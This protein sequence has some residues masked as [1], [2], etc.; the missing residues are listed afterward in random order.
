MPTWMRLVGRD[1]I[2][3]NMGWP[4][5]WGRS[6]DDY[7]VFTHLRPLHRNFRVAGEDR[8]VGRGVEGIRLLAGTYH[9]RNTYLWGPYIDAE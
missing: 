1:W 7:V 6:G 9:R 5:S 8:Q 3:V 4:V 2:G